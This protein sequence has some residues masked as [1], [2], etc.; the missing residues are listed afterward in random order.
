MV[1]L[2]KSDSTIKLQWI[3][4]EGISNDVCIPTMHLVSNQSARLLKPLNLK[5]WEMQ[6]R[7]EN[8][9]FWTIINPNG[10]YS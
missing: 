6:L 10:M 7:E 9:K 2:D 8:S 1:I 5:I 3:I 4:E